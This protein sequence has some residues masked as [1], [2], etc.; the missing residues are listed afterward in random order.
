MKKFTDSIKTIS[1]LSGMIILVRLI[2]LIPW[3]TF[4]IPVII[5]G[6]LV[7]HW[8]WQVSCFAA[9]FIAGFITWLGAGLY[10]HLSYQGLLF[11]RFGAGPQTGLFLVSALTGGILTGLAFYT[12]KTIVYRKT[13]NFI[14]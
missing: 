7:T 4:V 1:L 13:A 11:S 9:G 2:P 6:M 3:W 12:G 5:A 8:K 10:F 14:L